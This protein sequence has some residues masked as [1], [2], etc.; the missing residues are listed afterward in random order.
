MSNIHQY[1]SEEPDSSLYPT[2]RNLRTDFSLGYFLT[3]ALKM[4]ELG[5]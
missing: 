5:Q 2:I 3:E 1:T 4:Q